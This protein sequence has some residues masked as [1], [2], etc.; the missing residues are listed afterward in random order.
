MG[1]SEQSTVKLV[2]NGHD[3]SHEDHGHGHEGHL[4][5]GHE[6]ESVLDTAP[7][8]MMKGSEDH[9]HDHSH[10]EKSHDH[11]SHL[12]DHDISHDSHVNLQNDFQSASPRRLNTHDHRRE[13]L[14]SGSHRDEIP[15]NARIH[16]SMVLS[17][18]NISGSHENTESTIPIKSQVHE[19]GNHD[20]HEDHNHDDVHPYPVA[21]LLI[22]IGFFF[23]YFVEEVVHKVSTN[24]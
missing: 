8:A 16:E 12:H 13:N 2:N 20:H 17:L 24:S 1:R 18:E 15:A 5:E 19:N 7:K 21:E 11:D 9:S 3:S 14:P 22:C 6:Q 23:I 4:H 10:G